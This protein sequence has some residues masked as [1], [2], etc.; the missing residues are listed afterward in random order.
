MTQ[1]A[2]RGRI[3]RPRLP[4]R[5]P[6]TLALMVA[7][8]LGMGVFTVLVG[9]L[10]I[11][12]RD[13][14]IGLDRWTLVEVGARAPFLPTLANADAGAGANRLSFTIQDDR[15]QIRGDLTVRVAIYDLATD[16]DTPVAAQFAQFIS[17]ASESPL[18]VQHQHATGASLSDNARYVG[19]GIY[20]VPA[21]FPRPGTWGLEFQIAPGDVPFDAAEAEEVLFR[22]AVRARRAAPAVGQAALATPSR[23]LVDEP[24]LRR[25]TSDPTPEPGLYQLS[26]DDALANGRLLLLIF[27]TPAFCHSRTCAPALDVVKAVWRD[28][29]ADLDAIHVEVFENPED[30]SELREAAAFLAWDL[31]SEPWVFVIDGRGVIV[32]AY[33]GSV[34]DRELRGDVEGLVGG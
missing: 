14:P 32:A 11:S 16:P 13:D 19:A 21:Y 3:P 8:T 25:L 17:Y 20:V 6:G 15:G 4:R 26:I 31:P 10:L 18:P 2:R 33:E 22:L 9:V 5:R 29:A 30:P 1:A 23:T 7:V 24:D 28:H 12:W 34:T 27:A